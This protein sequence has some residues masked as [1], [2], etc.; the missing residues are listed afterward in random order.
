MTAKINRAEGDYERIGFRLCRRYG[1]VVDQQNQGRIVTV[2]IKII[3][4]TIIG[5]LPC[6]FS[7]TATARA[8]EQQ[9]LVRTSK[10]AMLRIAG[11][12]QSTTYATVMAVAT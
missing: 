4:M 5:R 10:S 3:G 2:N 11:Q 1:I 8:Q 12:A 6:F 7:Q 9:G